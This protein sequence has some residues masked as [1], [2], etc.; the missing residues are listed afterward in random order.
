MRALLLGA[1]LHD[2][3]K[4]GIS[5]A[6]LLKPGPLTEEEMASM[7][8]H[9]ALGLKI[10]GSSKWLQLAR[11]V[12][13]GHH[14]RFDG[15]GYPRGLTGTAIPLEARLFAIVDVFDALTSERPY[16]R[17]LS[18][19]ESLAVIQGAAGSQFDPDIVAAFCRIARDAYAA[20]HLATEAE[21]QDLLTELV[22]RHRQVLYDAGPMSPASFN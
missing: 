20:T 3:G 19:A 14:E 15:G 17:P 6:I 22:E 21:L 2:V 1:F 18:L 10:I 11:G 5:D 8:T 4:I 7:R 12:I 16:K 13:E 9:V